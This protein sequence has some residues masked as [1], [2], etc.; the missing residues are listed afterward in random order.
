MKAYLGKKLCTREIPEERGCFLEP[1]SAVTSPD[2][3]SSQPW[4]AAVD[5]S[6]ASQAR[7]PQVKTEDAL[8]AAAADTFAVSASFAKLVCEDRPGSSPGLRVKP[9]CGIPHIFRWNSI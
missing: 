6:E 5:C 3:L 2:A 7:V 4:T 1:G 9:I 8:S